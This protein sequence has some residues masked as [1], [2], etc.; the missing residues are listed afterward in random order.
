M[1]HLIYSYPIEEVH[2]KLKGKF[3]ASRRK[4]ANNKGERPNFSICYGTR[5]TTPSQAEMNRR[6]AFAA[7]AALV[8]ARMANL[9]KRA[10]D[11]AAAKAAGMTLKA[12]VWSLA[13]N[14]DLDDSSQG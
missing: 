11:K 3:G 9:T 6:D 12:Y 1:A 7:N 5:S 4:A 2:G 10:A 8:A 14:G 13:K